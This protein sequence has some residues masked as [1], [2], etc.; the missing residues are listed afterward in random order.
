MWSQFEFYHGVVWSF[1]FCI[2]GEVLLESGARHFEVVG[3]VVEVG[4]DDGVVAFELVVIDAVEDDAA[5]FL[6]FQFVAEPVGLGA[7]TLVFGGV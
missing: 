6:H 7:V 3:A 5:V 1:P 4:E 2:V